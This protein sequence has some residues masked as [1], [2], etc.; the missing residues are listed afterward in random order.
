M[1]G[2]EFLDY[3]REI[4][5]SIPFYTEYIEMR[6]R[7]D[8]STSRKDFFWDVIK[9]MDEAEKLEFFKSMIE[10]VEPKNPEGLNSLKALF[11][12]TDE[13]VIKKKEVPAP[14]FPNEVYKDVL[15]TLHECYRNAEQKPSL[16]KNKGEEDLRDYGLAFL[17]SR[18][19]S[20]VASGETFNKE[21]KTD[22]ILKSEKGENL[23]VAECK[24]WRGQDQFHQAIEQLFGYLTWRDTKTALILFVQNKKFSEILE[25]IKE[26]ATKNPYFIE[27][28]GDKEETSF[29]YKF[30][31]KDDEDRDVLVEIMAFSFPTDN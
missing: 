10:I 3:A 23:F 17:E 4:D 28:L 20:A 1:S 22:I 12:T 5:D 31:Y 14:K 16:Y 11:E 21:G 30:C 13:V 26:E 7:D 27:H 24:I 6:R 19:E 9:Q 2:S 15:D 25:K 29:S 18:Y 8:K